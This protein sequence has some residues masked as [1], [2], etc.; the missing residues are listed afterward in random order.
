M[1][2]ICPLFCI[3]TNKCQTSLSLIYVVHLSTHA[4]AFALATEG[5]CMCRAQ[6][7]KPLPTVHFLV[8]LQMDS[9]TEA[10]PTHGTGVGLLPCVHPLVPLE[11]RTM[12]EVPPTSLTPVGPL[13]RVDPLVDTQVLAPA[14]ALPTGLA[15]EWS[16][17]SVNTLVQVEVGS[18]AEAPATCVTHIGLVS[19][20]VLLVS[21]QR[22]A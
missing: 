12:P 21:C 20:V 8:R 13:S 10:L 3:N 17:P 2:L 22:R 11:G 5:T 4:L 14:E 6:S 1:L 9:L 18:L 15:P 16:L 7:W 19:C